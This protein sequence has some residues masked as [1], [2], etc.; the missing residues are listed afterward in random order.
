[1]IELN[2]LVRPVILFD[3]DGTLLP[4]DYPTFEKAYFSGL[5]RTLREVSPELLIR[6]VWKGVAA[7]VGNDG[8]RMNRD[9]FA[10]AFSSSTGLDYESRE[11]EFLR[12]YHTEFQNCREVC[13]LTELS[14]KIVDTLQGM[15]Y[16]VAIATNP[17]FPEIAT[18]S[19]LRWLGIDPKRFPLVTTFENSGTAKPNPEYY[20]E[21][22]CRLD[23]QP[24]DC[25]MIG[26]D[27]QED[28][29]AASVGMEVVLVRECLI[30]R[31]GSDAEKYKSVATLQEILLWAEQLPHM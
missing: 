7:M 2:H 11:G 19:R 12:Y 20:R 23:V 15:G 26:N 6:G 1:M 13:T 30:D 22:C 31:T 17:L 24:S 25:I 5:C 27:A 4:M 16:T 9:A 28:G 14:G 29:A 18:H 21:V 8:S 3:L 10:E